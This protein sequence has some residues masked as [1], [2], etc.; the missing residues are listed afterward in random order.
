MEKDN[1]EKKCLTDSDECGNFGVNY[2]KRQYRE[3]SLRQTWRDIASGSERLWTVFLF[4]LVAVIGSV[5]MGLALG[6]SSPSLVN[7]QSLLKQGR[8]D[9]EEFKDPKYGGDKNVQGMFG[10]SVTIRHI[11]YFII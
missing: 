11:Y 5:L 2:Q 6:Y 10:V 4:S 3:T 7:F 9:Y 8:L 1:S